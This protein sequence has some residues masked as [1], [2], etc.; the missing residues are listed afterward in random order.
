MKCFHLAQQLRHLVPLKLHENS[1]E[2]YVKHNYTLLTCAIFWDHK[3]QRTFVKNVAKE[4]W[5]EVS[6]YSLFLL[7]EQHN[8]WG[9]LHWQPLHW[10]IWGGTWD[11]STDLIPC[12]KLS[13][14]RYHIKPGKSVFVNVDYKITNNILWSML[15]LL[16]MGKIYN[17]SCW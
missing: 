7:L 17:L 15:K 6:L 11:A 14:Q 16:T 8:I 12:R 9:E 1:C 10:F 13:K 4:W 5:T 3:K 2:Q